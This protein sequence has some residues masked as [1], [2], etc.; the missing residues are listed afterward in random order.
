MPLCYD[1]YTKEREK[2]SVLEKGVRIG[3]EVAFLERITREVRRGART[4]ILADLAVPEAPN[5]T[6]TI[7]A[8]HLEN[9]C[10]PDCRRRQMD[11]VLTWI[12][13]I[14]HPLILAGDLNTTGSDAAPTSIFKIVKDRVVDPEFWAKKAVTTVATAP[15]MAV[16]NPVRY[17][18]NYSDPTGLHVPVLGPKRE[19]KLFRDVKA[20]RFNDGTAFDFRGTPAQTV[21]G[22]SGTLGDSNERAGKGFHY[23]FALQRNYGGVVGRYK[24]DWF[25]IKG[26]A[27][28]PDDRRQPLKWAPHFA[29]TLQEMNDLGGDRLSDHAPMTVD[30]PFTEPPTGRG[31]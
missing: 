26:F 1:W 29:R 14:D 23:T 10:Q 6:V 3:S 28:K 18:R 21:A 11:E 13:D 22:K 19:A 31:R 5:A 7:V 15:V 20:F 2:I 9:K 24:L 30:L 8:P 25:F 12:R 16:V 4:T 27:T 17:A